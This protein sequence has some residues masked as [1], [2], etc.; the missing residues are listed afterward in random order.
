M[1]NPDTGDIEALDAQPADYMHP[2][3]QAALILLL[4]R[5]GS[6]W[7]DPSMGSE[8]HQLRRSKDV[9]AAPARAEGYA[10]EA[11]KP[12]VSRG[13]AARVSVFAGIPVAGWLALTIDITDFAGR[14]TSITH[15]VE[16]GG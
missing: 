8:L 15:R 1:I 10:R 4:T 11:L 9:A 5:R 12:L 16:V 2:L 14:V 13:L 7:A 6:Y 3:I